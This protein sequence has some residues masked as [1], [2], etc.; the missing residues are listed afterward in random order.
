MIARYSAL[1]SCFRKSI[2]GFQGLNSTE[3]A[4]DWT[5]FTFCQ[6][7]IS[8]FLVGIVD[9][10]GVQALNSTRNVLDWTTLTFVR[11]SFPHFGSCF[12]LMGLAFGP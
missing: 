10:T 9:G 4:F 11:R 3:I 5:I 1:N 6:A 12:V 2:Y 8:T 7:F